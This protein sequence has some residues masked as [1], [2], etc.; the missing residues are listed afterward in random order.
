M[1]VI[2]VYHNKGGVGKTTTVVNLGAAFALQGFRVLLIDL[3]SQANTT[4]AT[5][6]LKFAF[7][8]EDDIKDCNIYHVIAEKN[9]FPIREVVRKASYCAVPIDVVP[10][11]I[12]LT[13]QE[14]ELAEK[15]FS[16][17]RLLDKLA[18]VRHDYDFVLIDCPPSRDLYSQIA[19]ISADYLLIPS[20]LKPFANTGLKNVKN[21][22]EEI[23]EFRN[24]ILKPD[25]AILGILPSK[26]LTNPGYVQHTLPR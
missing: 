18:Q 1:K 12:H 15:A 16:K 14:K 7:E 17:T 5:G 6:L 3:D 23:N 21:F 13:V 19:L 22:V 24:V 10:S 4:F 9:R 26:I 2:A 20:D 11:H 8:E 25:L